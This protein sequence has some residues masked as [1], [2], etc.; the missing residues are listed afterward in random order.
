MYVQHVHM[1]GHTMYVCMYVC[2]YECIRTVLVTNHD[3][4]FL[5]LF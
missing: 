3:G 1:Y 2:T 4:F 5:L